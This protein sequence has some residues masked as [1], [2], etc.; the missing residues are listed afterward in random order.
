MIELWKAI[1]DYIGQYEVS[2]FG[3]I[4]SLDR[5]AWNGKAKHPVK[6]R[7]LK[8]HLSCDRVKYQYVSLCKNSKYQHVA[9]HRMVALHFIPNPES[10]RYVGHKDSDP[11]NNHVENLEWCTAKENEEIKRRRFP[12]KGFDNPNAKLTREQVVKIKRMYSR[13][14]K[15]WEISKETGVNRSTVKNITSGRDWKHI[16]IL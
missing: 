6:G 16:N 2:N 3:R 9:V 7:T 8:L 15:I 10:K 1:T 13:G 5:M 4:R 14:I 11:L 12:Q